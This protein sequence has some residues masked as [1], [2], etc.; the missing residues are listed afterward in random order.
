M[1]RFDIMQQDRKADRSGE[2]CDDDAA[3]RGSKKAVLPPHLVVG[4]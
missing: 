1:V 4:R 2:N 3:K